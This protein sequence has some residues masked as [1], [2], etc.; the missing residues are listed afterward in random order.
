MPRQITVPPYPKKPHESGQARIILHVG[1][2]QRKDV[3]LG[4]FGSPESH[5][6]YNRVIA[7]WLANGHR[8][9]QAATPQPAG[10][11]VNELLD[12]YR[13][14][15]EQHYRDQDGNPSLELDNIR[16]AA[17][18]LRELYGHTAVSEFTSLALEAIQDHLVKGGGLACSTINVR[19]SRIRRIFKWGGRK[20]LVFVSLL[21]EL[22]TV[23][24]LQ[25]GRCGAPETDP[26][27]PVPV[28]VVEATLPFM[29]APVAAMVRLQLLSAC[30]PGE[31]MTLRSADLN[32]SG[33]LWVYRP[34]RHKNK[35]RGLDRVIFLGSQA[36]EIIR[37][38]LKTDL[39]AYLFSPREYVEALHA[40]RA[41]QRKTKR[42]PSEQHRKRKTKP[43]RKPAE[44]YNRRSYYVAITRAVDKANQKRAEQGLPPLPQWSPLQLRHTAATAIRKKYGIEVTRVICGHAKVETTQIYAERDLARAAEV[45]AE[46]G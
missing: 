38:F 1:P 2:R 35:H 16:L 21:Q 14:W 45:M 15:A 11:T 40:R 18:P 39:H 37:P 41:Q 29:P 32:T 31:V 23:P 19:I 7:E 42:T 44:R 22:Q 4:K 10:I 3:T 43:K 34:A 8:L 46:I 17:R 24:G 12:A 33:K 25:Q 5:E 13:L 6:A 20:K 30:R 27:Q 28:E 36:Q 9:P 26:V